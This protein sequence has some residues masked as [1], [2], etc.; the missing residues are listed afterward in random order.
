MTLPKAFKKGDMIVSVSQHQKRKSCDR[1]WWFDRVM[2]LPRMSKQATAFG[3]I[4]HAVC[5]RY[6]L[7]NDNMTV[8]DKLTCLGTALEGQREGEEVN[9]YPPGWASEGGH[10]LMPADQAIV[11]KLI[12]MAREDGTLCRIPGGKVEWEFWIKLMPGVWLVGLIDYTNFKEIQDHKTAKD[13][14]FLES[15]A[16]LPKNFQLGTYLYAVNEH[17]MSLGLEPLVEATVKHNQL[18]RGKPKK[19]RYPAEVASVRQTEATMDSDF[20]IK[21]IE[22]L[23]ESSEIMLELRARKVENWTDIE[24]PNEPDACSA[25]GGCSFADVCMHR[26]TTDGYRARVETLNSSQS[27]NSPKYPGVPEKSTM[28]LK[29]KIA[30]K[31]AAAATPALVEQ[32]EA[33]QAAAPVEQLPSYTSDS[34]PWANAGCSGCKDNP[35]PG[36]NKKGKP[37]RVCE[38]NLE[39]GKTNPNHHSHFNLDVDDDGDF[40]WERKAVVVEPEAVVEPEPEPEPE[41]KPTPR[42]AKLKAEVHGET[43]KIDPAMAAASEVAAPD[44]K[45]TLT[46]QERVGITDAQFAVMDKGKKGLTLLI[47]CVQQRG[48]TSSVFHLDRLMAGIM[49]KLEEDQGEC[50]TSLPNWGRRDAMAACVRTVVDLVGQGTIICGKIHPGSEASFFLPHLEPF[51]KTVIVSV[52]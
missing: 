6:L 45:G 40:T 35:T 5:E 46:E 36:F 9:L 38:S 27:N 10:T 23:R 49:A 21:C 39:G 17:R 26:E 32:P 8:P 42:K 43:E 25:Y 28:G 12:S 41:A 3:S 44:T 18:V 50:Y 19:G 20:A 33:A 1:A 14:R 24:G 7:A 16:S 48:S 30:A 11:K 47:G 37:C 51:A 34:A 31:K 15:K 13:T 22:E 52:D 4:T 29:E 2:K